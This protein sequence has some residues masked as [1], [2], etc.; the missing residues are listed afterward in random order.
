MS[1]QWNIPY[2]LIKQGT[3]Y[4]PPGGVVSGGFGGGYRGGAENR[5]ARTPPGVHPSD[6]RSRSGER[7]PTYGSPVKRSS[8]MIL[9]PTS[10]LDATFLSV[11]FSLRISLQRSR[12]SMDGLISNL[13]VASYFLVHS[14]F[15]WNN[16][17][18]FHP[19]NH[20]SHWT[21]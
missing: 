10:I 6:G 19:K 15:L 3:S 20:G 18:N 11:I 2:D 14:H 4:G 16:R 12:L 1:W 9:Y 8:G 13:C 21:N 17:E 5:G 7:Y